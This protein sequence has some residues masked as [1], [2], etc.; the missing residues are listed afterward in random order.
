M[1]PPQDRVRG[2]SFGTR[3][4]EPSGFTTKKRV[5]QLICKQGVGKK[6]ELHT[7]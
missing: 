2:R 4:V 1:K 6:I 7:R 3:C 5:G